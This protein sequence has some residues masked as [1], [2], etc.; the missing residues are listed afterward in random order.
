MLITSIPVGTYV[1]LSLDLAFAGGL[2]RSPKFAHCWGN[3]ATSS[4][5][6]GQSANHD[7]RMKTT[8]RLLVVCVLVSSSEIMSR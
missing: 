5:N 8:T 7:F 1:T 3:D 2:V 4:I 6:S